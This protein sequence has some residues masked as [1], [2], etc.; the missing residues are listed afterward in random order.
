MG[1]VN[2]KFKEIYFLAKDGM[3]ILDEGLE[4]GAMA[5]QVLMAQAVLEQINN[6]VK[7]G[8]KTLTTYASIVGEGLNDAR[9]NPNATLDEFAQQDIPSSTNLGDFEEGP[10]AIE[11]GQEEQA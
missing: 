11:A 3:D 5:A 10:A 8:K 6:A 1:E 9:R 2:D 7:E 4:P